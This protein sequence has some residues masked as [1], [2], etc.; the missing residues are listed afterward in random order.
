MSTLP[1]PRSVPELPAP[2]EAESADRNPAR[3]YVASLPSPQSRRA[4]ESAL[5]VLARMLTG[6]GLGGR[7]VAFALP[8]GQIRYQ[9]VAAI[10]AALID[11]GKPSTANAR[12]SVLRGVMR[13]AYLLG[14]IDADT[15]QRILAVKNVRA[16]AL[17]AG[18]SPSRR[19]LQ[20]LFDA[21]KEDNSPA[22]ARDAAVIAL[23]A[24]GGL[25]RAEAAALQW[26]DYDAE[27]GDLAVRGKGRRDRIVPIGNGTR[28][29][30]HAWLDHR[31][32]EP[33]PLFHAVN[34]AG[35]IGDG[36]LTTQGIFNLLQKRQQRARLKSLTPHDLRRSFATG[37]LD[38]GADVFSV[39][40]LMGHA[41]VQTTQRYDRR[42][43]QAKRKAIELLTIPY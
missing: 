21:C 20:R 38:A 3:V 22:G 42:D 15:L 30:L 29:A 39:Q 17:P 26:A 41:T 6:G 23:M 8:W 10:R 14:H 11:Q 28:D 36:G 35:T 19:E 1:A 7:E 5:T 31:G 33:G 34:K 18:R 12:L 43:E 32:D 13:Q 40:K 9:H 37:L 16:Q 27:I 25:R 4:A 2:A 24:G